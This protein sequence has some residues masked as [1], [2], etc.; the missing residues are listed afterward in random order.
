VVLVRMVSLALVLVVVTEPD[1][2][3]MLL[4]VL[5]PVLALVVDVVT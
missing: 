3:L 2:A 5:V 1:V 4:R